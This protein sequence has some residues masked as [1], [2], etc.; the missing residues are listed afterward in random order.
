MTSSWSPL[1]AY[2]LNTAPT[3]VF[4]K[5]SA[6]KPHHVQSGLRNSTHLV[7]FAL[8]FPLACREAAAQTSESSS[9]HIHPHL[10][11]GDPF[12]MSNG[13]E[14]TVTF[15]YL[16]HLLLFLFYISDTKKNRRRFLI[17]SKSYRLGGGVVAVSLPAIIHTLKGVEILSFHPSEQGER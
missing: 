17:S 2:T 16:T 5:S 3:T 8:V 1:P 11:H 14:N 6:S 13:L 4:C 15:S 9:A 10:G 12:R 7:S